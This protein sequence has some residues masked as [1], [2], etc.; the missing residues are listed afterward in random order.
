VIDDK[1]PVDLTRQTSRWLEI[2][3]SAVSHNAAAIRDLIGPHVAFYASLKADAYGYGMEAIGRAALA[4]GADALAVGS[5]SDALR[6]RSLGFSVP[7][8]VYH[9]GVPEPQVL[10]ALADQSVTLTVV[11]DATVSAYASLAP[12]RL[13][14]FL[15]VDVGLL[16]LGCAPEEALRLLRR[17]ADE[18]RL[19]LDGLYTHLDAPD[20][21]PDGY[22]RW[23]L[24]RFETLVHD[25]RAAGLSIP[26]AM[27]ASSGVLTRETGSTFDG[28][29]PGRLL[30][31]L[32]PPTTLPGTAS[33]L[34]V[35]VALK[36]RLV[37]VKVLSP[38][39]RFPDMGPFR[40]HA[41]MRI[42]V[43]PMGRWH[44]LDRATTER[45]LVRGRSVPLVG[46][47]S[48][49]HCRLDLSD[50]PDAEA[51]D[52]V[53]VIGRQGDAEITTQ[54]VAIATHGVAPLDITL[55]VG[56]RV[57]RVYSE[58]VAGDRP[59]SPARVNARAT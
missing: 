56:G 41:A 34:P 7:M 12:V 25:A 26:I 29:D 30:Y 57:E 35:L 8:L 2:D 27:A 24:D 37:Q 40:W 4:G 39:D 54:D 5:P 36:T 23:Q 3:L 13:G 52:E 31:G 45:M 53:V 51:G 46:G 14:V 22:L 16:R 58:M 10:R 38:R 48:I 47:A 59:A 50:V 18:P 6:L 1:R 49:E 20:E 43:V 15:K 19:Q 44:G 28:V 33:F 17:I 55:A 21:V 9:A 11:D 42:G 32:G